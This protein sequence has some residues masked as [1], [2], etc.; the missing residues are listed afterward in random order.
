MQV[1]SWHDP[2]SLSP[3]SGVAGNSRAGIANQTRERDPMQ[4][5]CWLIVLLVLLVPIWWGT[6]G[7]DPW[8]LDG[9]APGPTLKGMRSGFGP[10]W[11]ARDGPLQYPPASY[12][13]V[14]LTYAPALVLFKVTGELKTPSGTYPWGFTHPGLS[15]G[16]LVILA[17]LVAVVAAIVII[18][19]AVADLRSRGV[20]C[21]SALAAMLMIGSP[22]FVYYARTSN[23]DMHYLAWLWLGFAFVERRPA[24]LQR[25]VWAGS[26]AALAFCTKEQAAPIAAVILGAAV[27]GAWRLP[28]TG[29]SKPWTRAILP[30]LAGTVT[31]AVIWLLPLNH[32]GCLHHYDYLL[33]VAKYPRDFS[34]TPAGFLAFALRLVTYLPDTL[35]WPLILGIV[36]GLAL[37]MRVQGLRLRW[38]ALGLYLVWILGPIGYAYN[39]FLLPFLLVAVP[40]GCA[41]LER[42]ADLLA[43]RPVARGFSV[44]ALALAVLAGGPWLGVSMLADPRYQAEQWM[45]GALS[46]GTTVLLAGNPMFLPRVPPSMQVINLRDRPDATAA[47]KF[48]E[49]SVLV[50]GRFS[51]SSA[52]MLPGLTRSFRRSKF[53]RRFGLTIA[54]DIEVYR[55]VP[56]GAGD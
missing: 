32:A 37:S 51:P 17:R 27:I 12:Y 1:R 23:V 14:A 21:P 31:Y 9:I 39:R 40:I 6:D 16:V 54:P 15:M 48:P 55:R 25:L 3:A 22:V 52:A 41:G 49:N 38:L 53:T 33:H 56:P 30:L 20:R 5:I 44:V 4:R 36:S 24:T 34:M 29:H 47:A 18:R 19:L 7:K 11:D 2:G 10:G 28:E 13:L 26:A 43:R 35:G 45:N 46:P 42:T 8:D 50:C